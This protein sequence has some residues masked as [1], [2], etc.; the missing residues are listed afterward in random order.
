M[1]NDIFLYNSSTNQIELNTPEI[2]LVDEFKQL[3]DEKRNN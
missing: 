3:L 1:V 2:L